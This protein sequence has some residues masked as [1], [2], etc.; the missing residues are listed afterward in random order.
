MK[1]SSPALF[2]SPPKRSRAAIPPRQLPKNLPDI[3]RKRPL[4]FSHLRSWLQKQPLASQEGKNSYCWG[5]PTPAKEPDPCGPGLGAGVA[6][7]GNKVALYV[8]AGLAGA[9]GDAQAAELER[10]SFITAQREGWRRRK[11]ENPSS[12]QADGP[13]Q[14]GRT[15]LGSSNC[16]ATEVKEQTE[17]EVG[18]AV[19]EMRGK[20]G[21]RRVWIQQEHSLSF[22][23]AG[24]TQSQGNCSFGIV[25]GRGKC[26]LLPPH[27]TSPRWHLVQKAPLT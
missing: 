10:S 16:Q 19:G 27:H 18:M 23:C 6:Q 25:D 5:E 13:W 4:F 26:A 9:G 7:G 12:E 24:E 11:E 1:R 14:H 21:K 8:V 22:H 3:P 15:S 2:T 17:M 20:K